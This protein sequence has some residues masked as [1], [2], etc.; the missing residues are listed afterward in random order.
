MEKKLLFGGIFETHQ[1]W[2]E[3]GNVIQ[4]E[5]FYLRLYWNL[6]HSGMMKQLKGA[7]FH[8]LMTIAMHANKNAECFPSVRQM[9]KLLPY[10]KNAINKAINDLIDLGLLER[11]QQRAESGKFNHNTYKIKYQAPCPQK[12]D[13]VESEENKDISPCPQNT[14]TVK[15]VDRKS[16]LKEELSFKKDINNIYDLELAKRNWGV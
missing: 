6:W 3:F 8:V 2:D 11:E 14:D 15:P 4:R 16:G 5:E 7:R 9:E 1:E 10:N 13:T 12:I